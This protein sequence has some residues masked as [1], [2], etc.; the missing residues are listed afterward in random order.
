MASIYFKNKFEA[1]G[2]TSCKKT[3]YFNFFKLWDSY[4]LKI[5]DSDDLIN[6]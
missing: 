4:S 6:S 1:Y 5:K 3:K 2:L